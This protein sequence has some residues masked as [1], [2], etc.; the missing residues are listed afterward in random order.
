MPT[1][2]PNVSGGSCAWAH[3][4]HDTLSYRA[5]A[6]RQPVRSRPARH[7]G[8]DRR[9][10]VLAAR[11][12]AKCFQTTCPHNSQG[13]HHNRVFHQIEQIRREGRMAEVRQWVADL[14]EVTYLLGHSF[15]VSEAVE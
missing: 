6:S 5:P 14:R 10:Q 9:Q 8:L 12:G 15:F 1:D 4:V 7:L 3:V 13:H 2:V 11:N